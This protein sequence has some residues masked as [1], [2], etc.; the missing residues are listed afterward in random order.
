MLILLA[1]SHSARNSFCFIKSQ[2][3]PYHQ[4]DMY[5]FHLM[6]NYTRSLKTN[7]ATFV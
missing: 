7:P 4:Q 1:S 6:R 3:T 2:Q 5:R